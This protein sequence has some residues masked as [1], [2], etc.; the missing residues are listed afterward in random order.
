MSVSIFC[1]SIVTFVFLR[2]TLSYTKKR[3]Q[4]RYAKDK[5]KA[6]SIRAFRDLSKILFLFSMLTTLLGYWVDIPSFLVFHESVSLQLMGAL[7]V[8]LGYFGLNHAFAELDNNYS[9]L[10]DA[11]KPFT[12][13][14]SGVYAHIRHP[15]YA[16]NL[17]VSF[18]L[19]LSSGNVLVGIAA[20]TGLAFVLR[21][22]F[23]EEKFLKSEF[24][25]YTNYCSYTWRFFP[26]IF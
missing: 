7:V 6:P 16:F 1:T 15:I 13:T 10:F 8:L 20:C 2:M 18:G 25:E 12:L 22:V 19:A 24:V 9:P 26:Y 3:A 23:I 14:Q 4:Q 5:E 11:Y 17:C 21:A